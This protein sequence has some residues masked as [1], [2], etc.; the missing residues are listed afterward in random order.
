VRD[1]Q[2]LDGLANIFGYPTGSFE[3]GIRQDRGEFLSPVAG[4][5]IGGTMDTTE[6]SRRHLLETIIPV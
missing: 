5:E 1:A 3:I 4:H 2:I 6:E